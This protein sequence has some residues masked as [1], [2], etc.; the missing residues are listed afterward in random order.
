[1]KKKEISFRL[2]AKMHSFEVDENDSRFSRG[3]LNVFYIGCTA[4]KRLFD[5]EFSSKLIKTLPYAP[6]VAY[7]DEEKEDFVGHHPT[8]QSIYGLIDPKVEPTFETMDDGNVWATVDVVLYTERP[9]Q[10]GEIAK[11]IVGHSQSLEL[12]PNTVEYVINYD[13]KKKFKNIQFKEGEVIG[14]SVLGDS[15]DPAFTGSAFFS[16]NDF[17]AKMKM[18][19]DYCDKTQSSE[20]QENSEKGGSDMQ[21]QTPNF[22]ELSWQDISEKV[23][24]AIQKEYD[25]AY[26]ILLSSFDNHVVIYIYYFATG[27]SKYLDVHYTF[28]EQNGEVIFG[29]VVEV[30]PTYVPVENPTQDNSFDNGTTETENGSS[31]QTFEEEPAAATEN[32]TEPSATQVGDDGNDDNQQFADSQTSQGSTDGAA[33]LDGTSTNETENQE[34]ASSTSFDNSE[35]QELDNLNK[36]EKIKFLNDNKDC[37]T[38]EQ[39]DNFFSNIDSY[40]LSDLA[41]EFLTIVKN[42]PKAPTFRT[43]QNPMSLPSE[44]TSVKTDDLGHIVAKVLN[45]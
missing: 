39:Y 3:K 26:T 16:S 17:E 45:K 14:V 2:P 41:V 6:V 23:A 29:D 24:Q 20:T 19:K 38:T 4:D 27:E 40:E 42:A 12:N 13:E 5:E 21:H 32:P 10:V 11:K 18:L 34:G 37:L 7:Y 15:Q 1:M 43:F 30:R 8:K 22:M 36:E 31:A 25:D 28:D 44:D 35:Q 33:D 9:G